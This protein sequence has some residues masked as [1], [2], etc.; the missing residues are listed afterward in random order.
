MGDVVLSARIVTLSAALGAALV[1]AYVVLPTA[2]AEALFQVAAWGSIAWFAC[3]VVRV[4]A[5]RLP[6]RLIGIGLALF[7]TGDLWFTINDHVLGNSPFP[8]GA[9][10]AYLSGYL[11][12][13]TG[14]AALVRSSRSGRDR[15][16]LIDAGI[17][18]VPVAVATWIYLI[19]PFA[20]NGDLT[21]VERT[22]S[23][24]YP[25]GDL[26]CAAVL[27]RLLTT[28]ALTRRATQPSLG[29]LVFGVVVMLAGDVW[30]LASELAGTYHTGGWND[31]VFIV[32]YLAFGVAAN[33]SS[34]SNIGQP[35]PVSDVGLTR[36]RLVLLGLLALLTPGILV[37]QWFGS[38]PLA[39][40]L[41]VA[42]TALT[43]IL[44]V[45][46]MG[47][48]VNALDQ[49]RSQL[50]YDILH[51][52]LTGLPN[53]AY[54]IDHLEQTLRSGEAGSLLFIDL[55]RFKAVNDSLGHQAGDDLLRE[56]AKQ[57]QSSVRDSDVV[58]R[59]AGDEFVVL[60]H[61]DNETAVFMLASRLIERLN[62]AVGSDD[63]VVGG[64]NPV[65]ASINVTASVGLVHWPVGTPVTEADALLGKADTAMYEAKNARGNQLSIADSGPPQRMRPATRGQN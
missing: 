62:I 1:T 49:S 22:V 7:A 8:S 63:Q 3:G 46:R 4:G 45:A 56:V 52:V 57:L 23:V 10:I 5:V 21:I 37:V 53:R 64:P 61:T 34:L 43:F 35:I 54:F 40:P 28:T 11:F 38:G 30:F 59:L 25:L 24:A 15:I 16:A 14:L 50:Q 51:D 20:A 27:V 32:P 39:V 6:W 55:D 44:V 13:A 9:D 33:S 12:L 48:L 18:V 31:G 2:A 29:I 58:A 47:N 17:V 36:G 60:V 41:V 26:L 65:N 42:G 19:Q